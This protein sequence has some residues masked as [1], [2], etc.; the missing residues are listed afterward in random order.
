[1]PL[2]DLPQASL[3][4]KNHALRLAYWVLGSIAFIQI[5]AIGIG[6][7][8]SL[9]GRLSLASS[10]GQH[11][12]QTTNQNAKAKQSPNHP[13]GNTADD[14]KRINAIRPRTVEEMLKEAEAKD[15]SILTPQPQDTPQSTVAQQKKPTVPNQDIPV[16]N[17]LAKLL[18]EARYAQI[19]G[20]MKLSILKLEEASTQDPNHP[21]L[22]YY[23]A[24]AYEALRNADKSREYFLKVVTLHE[25]AGKYFPLA[26]KHLE[27][28]F[29]S[30]A[31]RR[32]DMSF[33]TILEYH[34]TDSVDGE[35]VVLTIPVLMKD[36]LNIRPEDIYIPIHFFDIANKKKIEPTRAEE[37]KV[38]WIS[39]PVDWA[40]G[41]EILEVTYHMAPLTTEELTAYGDLKYYGYSAKLYYKGE[42]MDCHATPNVL[43]LI[44]QMN[45]NRAS[46]QPNFDYGDGVLPP[47]DTQ[48]A[49]G[50]I[51]T[52]P[53]SSLIP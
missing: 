34:D 31:D 15:K 8:L 26:A 38:R 21:A 53:D 33:G 22:L 4:K 39:E 51:E 46:Q 48:P 5:M 30:P 50:N 3:T 16:S 19:E 42:P 36:D 18:K 25:K 7:T 41:E 45:Q 24:I 44:E 40:S 10:D 27:M 6:L 14:T 29:S 35:R 47:L 43:F 28:G 11:K 12:N 2:S 1:M 17:K 49:S 9:S 23:F 13:G 20:D 52:L 32:G 37:P